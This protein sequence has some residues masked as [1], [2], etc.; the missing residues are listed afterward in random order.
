MRAINS[1]SGKVSLARALSKL[2]YC[3]RA[4]AERIILEGRVRVEGKQ[5]R[6]SSVR[7]APECA[8]I[9]VDGKEVFKKDYVYI[10][11]NKPAGVVTTRSDEKG[12]KTVYDVLGDIENWLF[13]VGRLDKDTSGLLLL[14]NDTR[15][16]ERLTNPDSKI[17]KTYLVTLDKELSINDKKT[18]ERGM[19]L[20]GE[21]LKP[22]LVLKRDGVTYEFTIDEGKNRQIRRMCDSLGY[23][24]QRLIRLQIGKLTLGKLREGTWKYMTQKDIQLLFHS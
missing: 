9:T 8:M 24:V 5:M 6:N 7:I 2:G 16:G 4:V 19:M 18:M 17:S 11:L 3:S 10:V 23:K 20:A 22:A 21:R 13:P 15:F 12:R 14:T 1:S